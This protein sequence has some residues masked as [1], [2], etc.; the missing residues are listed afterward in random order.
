MHL[1]TIIMQLKLLHSL[2]RFFLK[3]HVN[4]LAKPIKIESVKGMSTVYKIHLEL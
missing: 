1:K 2:L 4:Y 3:H